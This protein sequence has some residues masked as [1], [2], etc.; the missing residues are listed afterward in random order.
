MCAR[1]RLVTDYSELKI[2]FWIKGN[3][4]APNLRPSW[5]VA[6]TQDLAVVVLNAGLERE[7]ATMRWGLIPSWCR[8]QKMAYST[9]NARAEGIQ[10]KPAFRDAWR[11]G[12][13]CLVI[14]NGFYEW[15]KRVAVRQPYAIARTMDDH[16]VM[17]GL[18]E[19]W[20]S[21]AGERMK[22]VT[23]ITT[24]ANGL[25]RRLHDRMPVILAE[26][27]W[28][29]WL[30]EAPASEADLKA[31]LKPYP[32]EQMRLWPVDRKVGNVKN[33]GPDLVRPVALE[34][35]PDLIL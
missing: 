29:K 15:D 21:P 24:E 8:E 33:D 27:D 2:K 11:A 7:L 13:R 31:M 26:A 20:T 3:A 34:A 19:E 9:F 23:I 32:S 5:N 10:N 17:A 14:T 18:W 16:T 6:P 35:K 28:P 12:R 4:Q 30:G 22:T 1:V 25:I